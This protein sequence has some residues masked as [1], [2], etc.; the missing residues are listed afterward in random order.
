[1]NTKRITDSGSKTQ[2]VSSLKSLVAAQKE[3][4]KGLQARMKTNTFIVEFLIAVIAVL[5]SIIIYQ[6]W[7]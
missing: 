1:M 4:L 5:T 7:F 3:T 6:V 2:S